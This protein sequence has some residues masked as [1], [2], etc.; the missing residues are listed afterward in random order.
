MISNHVFNTLM[1]LIYSHYPL[2][3]I[4]SIISKAPEELTLLV[5]FELSSL[6]PINENSY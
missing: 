4:L 6:M 5:G 3:S 1:M 2:T